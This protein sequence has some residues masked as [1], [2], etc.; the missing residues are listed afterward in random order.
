MQDYLPQKVQEAFVAT[1]TEF[2][3][4]PWREATRTALA[5]AWQGGSQVLTRCWPRHQ[6]ASFGRGYCR[7]VQVG[8]VQAHDRHGSVQK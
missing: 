3:L 1:L 7:S 6:M 5:G 2:V 8:T 4:L